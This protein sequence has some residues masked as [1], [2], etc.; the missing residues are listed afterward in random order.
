MG[1][2]RGFVSNEW[3]FYTENH[4]RVFLTYIPC[5]THTRVV[6]E[7]TGDLRVYRL[8]HHAYCVVAFSLGSIAPV[9]GCRSRT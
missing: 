4:C 8:D 7:R 5:V 1:V 2:I 3:Q 9:V 6:N